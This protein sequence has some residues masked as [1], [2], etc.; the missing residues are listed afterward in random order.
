MTAQRTRKLVKALGYSAFF[1]V[2]FVISLVITFPYDRLTGYAESQMQRV[3]GMQVSIEGMRPTITGGVYLEGVTLGPDIARPGR[4]APQSTSPYVRV[5][6]AWL[7]VSYIGLLLGWVDADFEA[8]I[9]NG[10]IEGAYEQDESHTALDLTV[11]SVEARGIPWLREKVGLPVHGTLTGDIDFDIPV[12]EAT[13]STGSVEFSFTEGVIGDGQAKLSL[14]SLMGYGGGQ[15]S[16]SGDEGTVIQ[17]IK[18]G[19]I[20]LKTKVVSGELE[21]PRIVAK[22][23]DAEITFE[24]DVKLGEPLPTTR[25]DTY[26]TVKLT[27]SYA[28]QDEQTETLVTLANTVG[29][30]AK[31]DDGSFGFRIRGTFLRGVNFRPSKRFNVGRRGSRRR[32]RRSARRPSRRSSASARRRPPPRE[33]PQRSTSDDDESESQRP[34]PRR[35]PGATIAPRPS[36]VSPNQRAARHPSGMPR[37]ASRTSPNVVGGDTADDTVEDY[38]DEEVEEEIVDEEHGDEEYEE[39]EEELEEELEE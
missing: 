36:I 35:P 5:D 4:P 28:E 1:G 13:K 9:A 10:T 27:D 26:L 19:P 22:S 30:R 8:E 29:M 24:G 15:S 33:R 11:A 21:I 3:M 16:S 7:G 39:Q 6:R 23:S 31:R 17:P 32:P 14:S 12:G 37:R 38:E 25:V 34:S 2:C 20:A 18:L